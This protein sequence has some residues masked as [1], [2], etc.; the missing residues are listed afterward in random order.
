MDAG[1]AV[2]TGPAV[3]GPSPGAAAAA[4]TADLV[5]RPGPGIPA[6][7]RIPAEELRER[8]S[9]SSGPGGQSVN[10]TDSRVELRWDI[11]SSRILDDWQRQRLTSRLAGRI[12]NGTISVVASQERSQYRNRALAREQLAEQLRA[13]LA[14]DPAPR[15]ATKPS[16]A[17]RQRRL[18]TKRHRAELKAGRGRLR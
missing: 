18:D 7:L 14:P 5:L 10:T 16:R 12:V 4:R 15:R 9:R 8:F 6:G 11:D 1:S 13:A 3:T 2:T 17:A